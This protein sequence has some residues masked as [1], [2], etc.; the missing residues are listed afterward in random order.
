MVSVGLITGIALV[1]FF[2]IQEFIVIVGQLLLLLIFL[3]SKI[4]GV[5]LRYFYK[6]TIGQSYLVGVSLKFIFLFILLIIFAKNI[7]I[8]N[9]QVGGMF[10]VSYAIYLV[11]DVLL[12]MK[13]IRQSRA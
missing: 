4:I 1:L 7:E 8:R 9:N 3:V 2:D 5:L 11:S 6:L 10:L 12:N 13:E